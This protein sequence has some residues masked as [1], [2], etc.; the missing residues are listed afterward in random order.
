MFTAPSYSVFVNWFG[1]S[2]KTPIAV[3]AEISEAL[4]GSRMLQGCRL[5]ID[6]AEKT[7]KLEQTT[8]G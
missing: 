7:V 4:L 3:S 6:Y 8:L 1:E 2:L 5:T